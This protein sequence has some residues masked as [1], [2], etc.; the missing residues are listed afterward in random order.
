MK[1]ANREVLDHGSLPQLLLQRARHTSDRRLVIDAAL[2]LSLSAALAVFRP[3]FW[4]P[5]AAL[6]LCLGT[7]GLWGILDRELIDGD[8]SARRAKILTVARGFV[9]ALGA[10]VAVLFGVTLFFGVLG[11]WIS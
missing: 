7:Y 1:D 4:L 5:L 10:V 11:T 3:P 2:G 6:A 8:L 9:G